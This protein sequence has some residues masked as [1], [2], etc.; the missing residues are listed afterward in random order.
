M[1]NYFKDSTQFQAQGALVHQ[2]TCVSETELH[3]TWNSTYSHYIL[4]GWRFLNMRPQAHT[5]KLCFCNF[6]VAV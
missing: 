5:A 1:L 4:V 6:Q 3:F 2:I